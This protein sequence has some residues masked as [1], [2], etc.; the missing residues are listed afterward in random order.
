MAILD[1][2][3][4]SIVLK[5]KVNIRVA[6]PQKIGRSTGNNLDL[7]YSEKEYKVLYLLHGITDDYTCW[8]RHTNI[9]RY[10]E[11]KNI[12]VVMPSANNSFYCNMAHGPRYYD[13]IVD[14]LPKFIK[15]LFPIST[16]REDTFIAGLS[17]G[18]YGAIKIALKNPNKYAA[19]ASLSGA[20]D[21][22]GG[23]EGLYRMDMIPENIFGDCACLE[24]SGENIFS[25]LEKNKINADKIPPMYLAV[26]YDDFMYEANVNFNKLAEKLK[27]NIIF[28]SDKGGH[29]WNFWDKYIQE[30]LVWINKM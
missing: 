20:L 15:M 7:I 19:V 21:I 12:L 18:G 28:V 10:A 16:K 23:L 17:M 3:F 22:I 1:C 8:S 25:L 6:V 29:E 26:G 4:H 14:E 11:D 13:F 2:N 9:E 5:T 24:E 30:V 27:Y